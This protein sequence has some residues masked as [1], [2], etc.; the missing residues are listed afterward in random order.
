MLS[1]SILQYCRPSFSFHLS[2]RPLFCLV[3]SDRLRQVL[4]CI[5]LFHFSII[6]VGAEC[7]F[8]EYLQSPIDEHGEPMAWQTKMWWLNLRNDPK[9]REKQD[10]YV[11]RSQIW[12]QKQNNRRSCERPS[13]R[14]HH[15]AT[16]STASF[17]N[18]SERYLLYNRTCLQEES[19]G[20]FRVI[21]YGPGRYV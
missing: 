3:L 17:G 14:V 7:I 12:S 4:L 11:Q 18:C 10:V 1:W 21:Q 19:F 13:R 15:R 5:K 16:S 9:L 20:R 8:P 2:L 6:G